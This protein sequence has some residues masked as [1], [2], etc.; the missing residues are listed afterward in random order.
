[1]RY[2]FRR[3]VPFGTTHWVVPMP[4]RGTGAYRR[5]GTTHFVFDPLTFIERLAALVPRPGVH[6]GHL[7]RSARTG[8]DMA[9]QDRA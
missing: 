6:L 2:E 9:G 7:P 1:M 4:L 8:L 5:D 3:R